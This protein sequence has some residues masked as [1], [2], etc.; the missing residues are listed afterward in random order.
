MPYRLRVG[1]WTR[2]LLVLPLPEEREVYEDLLVKPSFD[3]Q[4]RAL[5]LEVGLSVKGGGA[6]HHR[7]EKGKE[8]LERAFSFTRYQARLALMPWEPRFCI[9]E[10]EFE[11]AGQGED[12]DVLTWRLPPRHD[13]PWPSVGGIAHLPVAEGAALAL[14]ELRMRALSARQ[15]GADVKLFCR[16]V[17]DW[18]RSLVPGPD[19]HDAIEGSNPLGVL[20]D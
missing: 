3:D 7:Y 14:R 16:A 18:V 19:W 12:F 4:A 8:G 13:L 11:H 1:L 15:A 20:A 10:V 5:H 6:L 9:H 2:L 17:P